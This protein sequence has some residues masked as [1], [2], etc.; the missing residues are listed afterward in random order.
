MDPHT[1]RKNRT[2]SHR[3]LMLFTVSLW[4]C[5]AGSAGE[6]TS[7]PRRQ[8]V[9]NP[10]GDLS[11]SSAVRLNRYA[12][13]VSDAS[14][15]ASQLRVDST[16]LATM[17]LQRGDLLLVMQAQG[18]QINT[19]A[20]GAGAESHGAV[21]QLAGA[22]R[23]ELVPV[24]SA[25]PATGVIQVSGLC[26]GLRNAYSVAGNSQ[27]VRVPQYGDLTI[28]SGGVLSAQPWNGSTGG[29]VAV[30]ARHLRVSSGG[31]LHADAAGFRGGVARAASGNKSPGLDVAS[32]ASAAVD[33]GA[34]KGEGIAGRLSTLGRGAAG[35]GGG[36]GNAYGAG[37]AGGA[38]AGAAAAWTGHG[39]MRLVGAGDALAW[40][41]DPVGSAGLS[42]A[43]GGGRGGYSLAQSDR[44]ATLLGPGDSL[45]GGN[46]RRE[47]GGR[48]GYPLSNSAASQIFFGGGGGAGDRISSAAVSGSE[49]GG[50]RGGGLVY[51]LA[52]LV[53]GDGVIAARGEAGFSTQ[54]GAVGGGGGGGGGGSIVLNALSLSGSL[55][56][57]ASGGDGGSQQRAGLS[58]FNDALGPGGGGGGGFIA[59][60]QSASATTVQ[61]ALGGAA[62]TSAADIVSEF[63]QNGATA[64]R[65]GQTGAALNPG[66]VATPICSPVDLRIAVTDGVDHAAPDSEVSYL[67][68]V[69]NDGPYTAIAAPVNG[70]LT[71]RAD[72]VDWSCTVDPGPQG[73]AA[74]V[75]CSPA[76]GISNVNTQVTLPP[77]AQARIVVR[78][79]LASD[80]SG[81]MTYAASVAAASTQQDVDSSNNSASDTTQVGPEADLLVEALVAPSPTQSGQSLSYILSV[82]N[83]GF[84]TASDLKLSF[85]LP[86]QAQLVTAFPPRG[87]GWDCQSQAAAPQV[88]CTRPT[89]DY[90]AASDVV[91]TVQPP[92]NATSAVGTAQ[93]S[94]AALDPDPSN[95]AATAVAD[96]E[97][98]ITRY[99]R[100]VFAGG[101]VACSVD[102]RRGSGSG[103]GL[104]TTG[105]LLGFWLLAQRRRRRAAH[106]IFH[107]LP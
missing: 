26:G 19:T 43:S 37:G 17:A 90:G 20:S 62:G 12:R 60:P 36:G 50:G 98:D 102:P 39:V 93:V 15:G 72:F 96:I 75:G 92:F 64:G 79:I 46:F 41:V 18:A 78:A 14:A 42:N 99:R 52:D 100:S 16:E 9:E 67:I 32:F 107:P 38:N 4:A 13:L 5:A 69:Y 85:L 70:A 104:L 82:R 63:G 49:G 68:T 54:T 105:L 66:G 81:P 61:R 29:V 45:W 55:Q 34:E 88:I 35:N 6:D 40:M 1:V 24:E 77:G 31:I 27:V 33:D 58:A 44:D 71:P 48:G 86:D 76:R 87:D 53:D 94:S 101:G 47:R 51:V 3:L 22:G 25:N 91:V 103:E 83:L 7:Q 95:N 97:Y 65:D 11:L 2:V 10:D 57:V 56:L 8:P 74:G 28:A 106:R 59:L 21:T 84:N 30:R 23:F 80:R 73:S 89:L